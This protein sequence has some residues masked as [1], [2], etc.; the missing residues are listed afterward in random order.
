M[1]NYIFC[2]FFMLFFFRSISVG[3]GSDVGS[4]LVGQTFNPLA[5]AQSKRMQALFRIIEKKQKNVEKLIQ[6]QTQ[7]H[8]KTIKK[9]VWKLPCFCTRFL[10]T[11]SHI[12]AP[13]WVHFGSTLVPFWHQKVDALSDARQEAP[14]E[15]FGSILAPFWLHFYSILASF[16]INV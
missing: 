4:K 12:W 8:R 15:H 13:F 16:G 11:F 2:M 10:L 9:C 14:Q 1:K 6:K 5:M 7:N 3:F